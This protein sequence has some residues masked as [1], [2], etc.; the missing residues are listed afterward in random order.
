MKHRFLLALIASG[1]LAGAQEGRM[2]GF[3][4][5]FFDPAGRAT[6]KLTGND[7]VLGSTIRLREAVVSF[8]DPSQPGEAGLAQLFLDEARFTQK[9]QIVT[10]VGELR[11][12][13]AEGNV[14]GNG[15]R[16]DVGGDRFT[17]S[18]GFRIE[19]PEGTVEGREAEVKLGRANG[20]PT[21]EAF[22]GRG[23]IVFTP[24][25]PEEH[26][27][28]RAESERAWYAATDGML[29][30]ASPV[31]STYKGETSVADFEKLQQPLRLKR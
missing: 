17:I 24:K 3:S 28:E 19:M 8:I 9:E 20:K 16:Y 7:A 14:T 25:N 13:S 27:V 22:E 21:I 31:R 18:E 2:S 6:R 11:Y 10:G 26:K 12:R 4:V 15:Y 23:K 5:S 1:V 29:N 30:L